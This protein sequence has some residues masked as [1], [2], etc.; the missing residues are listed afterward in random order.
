MDAAQA[1]YRLERP[2]WGSS[3]PALAGK[4]PIR[5]GDEFAT[6]AA[7]SPHTEAVNQGA[8]LPTR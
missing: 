6:G 4:I 8:Y 1:G 2:I 3:R 5:S 7:R